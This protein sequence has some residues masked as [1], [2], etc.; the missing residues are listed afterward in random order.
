MFGGTAFHLCLAFL[1]A[2]IACL[3]FRF[4]CAHAIFINMCSVW[5][6]R[7]FGCIAVQCLCSGVLDFVLLGLHHGSSLRSAECVFILLILHFMDHP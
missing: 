7:S 6:R 5:S 3:I 1:C 4:C 2:H